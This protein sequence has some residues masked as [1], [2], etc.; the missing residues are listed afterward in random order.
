MTATRTSETNKVTYENVILLFC[1]SCE[2]QES[3]AAFRYGIRSEI[4]YGEEELE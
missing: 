3:I 2:V 4:F 1:G